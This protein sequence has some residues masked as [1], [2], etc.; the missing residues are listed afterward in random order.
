[1]SSNATAA[2]R[3][4]W[5]LIVRDGCI[6][7]GAP[8]E[9]AHC[10]GGSITERTGEKAKGK[11][12]QYMHWL[13]LNLCPPHGRYGPLALDTNVEEWEERNGPQTYYIDKLIERTGVN[14]WALARSRHDLTEPA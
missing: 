8:A 7:C 10:H 4:Y 5:T 3:R 12:L 9:I 1:M 11:K 6:L 14:V 13:T 2:Q